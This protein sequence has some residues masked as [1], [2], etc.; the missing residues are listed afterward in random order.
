MT[1]LREAAL[2]RGAQV[3]AKADRPSQRRCD[4]R[5]GSLPTARMHV[6][7]LELRAS[8]SAPG[9]L[10]FRGYASVTNAAY[11]MWDMF[12]PYTEQVAA[13]AFGKTLA[14]SGL[15]VPFVL[16]HDSLRRIARTSNGSLTLREDETGL[17]VEADRLDP[18]DP[19][20]AYIAPKLRAGLIDEMSFRFRITAGSWSPDWSEYHIEEV[21]LHRG[22]VAIVGYGA[23]PHTAGASLRSSDLTSLP[24][25]ALRAELARRAPAS[26]MS[27]AML[28]LIAAD[29]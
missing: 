12:G 3:R 17:L 25:E 16:Q 15:D 26:A 8:D 5:A 19:D 2:A 9:F 21:D 11:E 7:G 13:G 6:T 18:E 28:A 10:S 24:D 1:A 14:Q 4:E 23:N 29:L 22:D 27:R 20:V